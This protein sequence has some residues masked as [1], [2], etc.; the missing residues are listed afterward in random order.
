VRV[1]EA[2]ARDAY[3]RIAVLAAER[4]GLIGRPA[5]AGA[6]ARSMQDWLEQA[7]R[8]PNGGTGSKFNTRTSAALEDSDFCVG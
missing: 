5:A 4:A 7:Q 8:S 3:A 6:N 1:A 2:T